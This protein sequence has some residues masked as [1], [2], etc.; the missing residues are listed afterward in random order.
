[1]TT[2]ELKQ[3]IDKVLGNSIRCL[4][5]SYWWKRLF[6]QVADRIDDKQDILV[7]GKNIKTINGKDLLGEGDTNADI[8]INSVDELNALDLP[9]GSRASV[10]TGGPVLSSI[11]DCVGSEIPTQWTRI[12]GIKI[13]SAPVFPEGIDEIVLYFT[14]YGSSK[15][16]SY[17]IVTPT[18]IGVLNMS[19]NNVFVLSSNGKD[20]NQSAVDRFNKYLQ[21]GDY[22]LVLHEGYIE[23]VGDF[24]DSFIK[25]YIYHPTISEVY[26]KGET[27]TRLL[28]EGDVTGGD[29]KSVLFYMP[30]ND[31]LSD[32]QKQTNAESYKKIVDGFKNNVY[33]NVKVFGLYAVIDATVVGNALLTEGR[34]ALMFDMLN[35]WQVMEVLEDGSATV[36]EVDAWKGCEI[37]EF[38]IGDSLTDQQ[39]AWNLET[40][41]MVEEKK[42]TTVFKVNAPINI[43]PAG[44]TIPLSAFVD[45]TFLYV[46]S[47]GV[48]AAFVSIT[49][50][51][52]GNSDITTES[53]YAD[54]SL[55]TTST[56]AVQNRVVTAALNKKQ[57]TLVS[58]ENIKTINNQS[59]L[60]SGNITIEGGNDVIVD[61]AM[62]STS[63]NPVQNKVVTEALSKTQKAVRVFV[64][65]NEL[66]TLIQEVLADQY[67]SLDIDAERFEYVFGTFMK[68]NYYSLYYM[69]IALVE[70]SLYPPYW[71][72]TERLA[73][74]DEIGI[75][76]TKRE[77]DIKTRDYTYTSIYL[78]YDP[79]YPDP[80]TIEAE[81]WV[82]PES[83]LRGSYTAYVDEKLAN[84]T[85]PK[86]KTINSVS[87][88]GEGNIEL[89]MS[90]I[91]K[92]LQ[93][94]KTAVLNNEEALAAALNDI[95]RR[96]LELENLSN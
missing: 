19:T 74:D 42:C 33:Y 47:S 44:T 82:I 91:H 72:L 95:N 60:G 54:S 87:L 6:N 36:E 76:F 34:I 38:Y 10:V 9:T 32:I 26:I 11:R 23:E 4:L 65:P 37:R 59:I 7:S 13:D 18:V 71:S 15:Y 52:N 31:G 80:Y 75:E 16:E 70:D 56:N 5:P 96:L 69:D 88:S 17:I 27:W 92:K 40:A 67:H 78:S 86:V 62:S 63:T 45:R 94:I 50:D 85:I 90:E 51:S 79:E 29:S 2:Q 1:M 64:N 41:M 55:S 49:I 61:S 93:D 81:R 28:K 20:I 39:K 30:L 84:V 3:Q 58:G 43:L 35:A 22:R 46:L 83:E 68:D 77:L 89:H 21:S 8:I 53:V 48:N 73:S 66:E 24:I 57:D 12:S 25:F 14:P